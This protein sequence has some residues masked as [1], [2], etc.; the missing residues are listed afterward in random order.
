MKPVRA[1]LQT[2]RLL[3]GASAPLFGNLVWLC[4]GALLCPPLHQGGL[5]VRLN[6]LFE[7]LPYE[8]VLQLT[9]THHAPNV[10][11]TSA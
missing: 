3:G 1:A 5:L 6:E 10:C 2:I 7:R 4:E 11:S 9:T 8:L